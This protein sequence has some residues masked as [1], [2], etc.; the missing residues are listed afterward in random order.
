MNGGSEE[1]PIPS[2]MSLA[3]QKGKI[4][5]D[6]IDDLVSRGRDLKLIQAILKILSLGLIDLRAFESHHLIA[7]TLTTL[8]AP[9]HREW[10][11]S[12]DFEED[13]FSD[14]RLYSRGTADEGLIAPGEFDLDRLLAQ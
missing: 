4:V 3:E 13:G 1:E 5:A 12:M 7:Y 11:I 10:L 6:M 9:E 8:V 14:I 2:T